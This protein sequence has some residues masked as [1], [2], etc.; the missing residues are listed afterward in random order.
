MRS[1]VNKLLTNIR[2]NDFVPLKPA[3]AIF[4]QYSQSYLTQ[5]KNGRLAV[6]PLL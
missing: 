5:T 6:W 4:V 1:D 2:S 3:I